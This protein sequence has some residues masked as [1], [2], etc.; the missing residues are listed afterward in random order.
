MGDR[1]IH[2]TACV[3]DEA[4]IGKGTNV[5]NYA[6]V[7]EKASIGM[8]CILSKGVYI[9]TNVVVGNNVKIQNNV[10]I[11]QGVKIEDGCFIGPHV[12]FTNDKIPRAVNPDGTIKSADDWKISSTVVKEGA[13][14]GANATI[15]P[16][17]SIGRFVMIGSG[18]V[19][20][21]DIPDFALAFGNPAK[22]VDHVCKCGERLST[23]KGEVCNSCNISLE[24]IRADEEGK[25]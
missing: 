24:K 2:E 14:I 16:G 13:S 17:V 22:V 15:L 11:Y 20:T 10:S 9:D 4:D 6:Q 1:Y 19:V 5:W 21:K 12:C 8:N 3:S 25:K 7:R 23:K 18:S